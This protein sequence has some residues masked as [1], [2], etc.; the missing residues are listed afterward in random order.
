MIEFHTVEV[1]LYVRVLTHVGVADITD[2]WQG[3]KH[4]TA[5][6]RSIAPRSMPSLPSMEA[7]LYCDAVVEAIY[8]SVNDFMLLRGQKSRAFEQSSSSWDFVRE[9]VLP[10]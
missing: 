8:L 4:H 10:F 5:Q 3:G 2:T 7:L 1:V 9:N 6:K